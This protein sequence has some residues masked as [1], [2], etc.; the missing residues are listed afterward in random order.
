VSD[1]RFDLSYSGVMRPGADP[2]Q[3]RR[4]LTDAF[5]LS[6]QDAARLFSGRPMLIK[7][8]V[9]AATAARVE[10]VFARAGAVLTVRPVAD[11]DAQ[12]GSGAAVPPGTLVTSRDPD[13]A[14]SRLTLAPPGELIDHSPVPTP[15]ALDLSRLSLVPGDDWTLAD[16]T[17]PPAKIPVPD[18]SRLSLV[19][20]L[21]RVEYPHDPELD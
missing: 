8:G 3:A 5:R 7:R 2:V 6:D 11:P 9:D 20:I 18:T 17:P 10:Q 16:C 21:P 4:L 12:V 1:Q 19:P 13:L 14:A 15:P